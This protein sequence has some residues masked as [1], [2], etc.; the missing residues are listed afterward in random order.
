[1][2]VIDSCC[3]RC[4]KNVERC[5]IYNSSS[6]NDINKA[7]ELYGIGCQFSVINPYMRIAMDLNTG[8]RIDDIN[9]IVFRKYMENVSILL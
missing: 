2:V 4:K 6:I 7:N 8:I 3:R 9:S 1:M 5:F